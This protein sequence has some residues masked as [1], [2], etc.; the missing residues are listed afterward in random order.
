MEL[1]I[2]I[3]MIALH[4]VADFILQGM[5]GSLKQKE[6]WIKNYPQYM[7]KN[8]PC[9][10]DYIVALIC[11]SFLW[12]FLIMIPIGIYLNFEFSSTKFLIIL[13]INTAIHSMIDDLKANHHVINLQLD[14]LF[15]FI[16]II[17]TFAFFFP[18]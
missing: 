15:H 5:M 7:G 3:T 8:K 2:F 9:E 16:Q 11:H 18:W 17:A 6:W 14:Q 10:Y 13:L 12:S 1:Y 4:I